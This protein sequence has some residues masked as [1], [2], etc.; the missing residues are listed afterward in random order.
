MT[1]NRFDK[2]PYL[3]HKYLL[4][5]ARP[6]DE[7]HYD[8]IRENSSDKFM[9]NK[10]FAHFHCYD[11]N[12]FREIDKKCLE[13]LTKNV[14]LIVTYSIGKDIPNDK[15][16]ILK[17]PNK[18]MD[19]GGKFIFVDYLKKKKSDYRYAIFLHFKSNK[20]RRMQY[21]CPL[22]NNINL[23]MESID[24]N[25]DIGVYVPPLIIYNGVYIVD[26]DKFYKVYNNRTN[27]DM[28]NN[29][30]MAEIV[31]YLG[32]TADN[33][34]PEGNC[35]VLKK[36]IINCAF[37][38]KLLYNILNTPTSFDV[39]WVLNYYKCMKENTNIYDVYEYYKNNNMC[40]NCMTLLNIPKKINHHVRVPR[41]GM[42]EHCFERLIFRFAEKLNLKIKIM[43]SSSKYDGK[44]NKT[45]RIINAYLGNKQYKTML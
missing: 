25:D 19:I 7:I 22:I 20:T 35:Y 14:S 2:Y 17:I 40:P 34:F 32:L 4:N 12:N 15:F 16:T 41:D 38:D 6:E 29:K 30:Y 27:Y 8:V 13:T 28:A 33:L 39:S 1:E 43:S 24:E 44:I 3:F 18:G 36:D 31:D 37:S 42:I 10:I 21:F 26:Y 5:I 9:N 45:T 23:I 11:I